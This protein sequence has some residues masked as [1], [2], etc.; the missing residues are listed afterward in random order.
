MS[1]AVPIRRSGQQAIS[2]IVARLE[3]LGLIERRVGRGRTV[4]L[5]ATEQGRLLAEEAVT[6]EEAVDRD[7]R[8]LL[9]NQVYETL[10]QLLVSSRDVLRDQPDR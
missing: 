1:C 7:I 5:H 6:R 2:H 8:D 9:G 10:R 4:E 3:K